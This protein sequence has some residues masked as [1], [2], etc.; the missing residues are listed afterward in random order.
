MAQLH[1]AVELDEADFVDPA[2]AFKDE[3]GRWFLDDPF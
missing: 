3:G 1:A 2:I